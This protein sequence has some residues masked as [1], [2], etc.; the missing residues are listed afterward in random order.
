MLLTV[1]IAG[2]LWLIWNGDRPLVPPELH[3]GALFS[4]WL[5]PIFLVLLELREFHTSYQA[6]HTLMGTEDG[7]SLTPVLDLVSLCI[8]PLGLWL[9]FPDGMS[10]VFICTVSVVCLNFIKMMRRIVVDSVTYSR[11]R[12]SPSPRFWPSIFPCLWASYATL[13]Q[14]SAISSDDYVGSRAH[15]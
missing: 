5:P 3:P 7:L 1:C 13:D 10:G 14:C 6:Y 11:F 4:S 9:R 15:S 2:L 12:S 8:R